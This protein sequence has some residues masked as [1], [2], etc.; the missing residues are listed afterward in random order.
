MEEDDPLSH[1]L[2]GIL[3]DLLVVEGEPG[4]NIRLLHTHVINLLTTVP[5]SYST[6][7]MNVLPL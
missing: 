7:F 3:R 6:I 4:T 5:V 1:R 2:V